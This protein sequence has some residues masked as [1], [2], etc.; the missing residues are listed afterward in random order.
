[1]NRS[2]LVTA[3]AKA[4]RS[5]HPWKIGQDKFSAF[6]GDLPKE[7]LEERQAYD[8]LVE[9]AKGFKHCGLIL[10]EVKIEVKLTLD[11]LIAWEIYLHAERYAA[12][13]AARHDI[14]TTDIKKALKD[15][16]KGT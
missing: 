8:I 10:S 7:F 2:E 3:I 13:G 11:Q 4:V 5:K 9:K 1:M 15:L 12:E 16:E 14:R 6:F